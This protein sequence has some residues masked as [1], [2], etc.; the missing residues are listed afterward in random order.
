MDRSFT[1][2]ASD[3]AALGVVT[4]L[5]LLWTCFIDSPCLFPVWLR[6]N[7]DEV[8]VVFY[9]YSFK[10]FSNGGQSDSTMGKV[11]AVHMVH[12]GFIPG[13]SDGIL[14]P[15]GVIHEYRAW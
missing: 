11:F 14:S 9:A 3:G 5:C 2:D 13:S 1:S 8:Q 6:K 7:D 10:K 4:G 12:L 15:L